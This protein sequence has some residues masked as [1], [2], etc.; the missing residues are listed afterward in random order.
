M[1]TGVVLVS[2]AEREYGE[3]VTVHHAQRRDELGENN[4]SLLPMHFFHKENKKA[5]ALKWK[6]SRLG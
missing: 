3:L 2:S 4:L 5:L 1:D 6:F